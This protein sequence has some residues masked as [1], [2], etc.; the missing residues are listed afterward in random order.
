VFYVA[1]KEEHDL[2][3]QKKAICLTKKILFSVN[4]TDF[5][6]MNKSVNCL[7]SM[8]VVLEN[9]TDHK[10]KKS[11]QVD[12]ANRVLSS[13]TTSN[14]CEL[15][16]NLKIE[17]HNSIYPDETCI[18]LKSD[19]YISTAEFLNFTSTYDFDNC[20][21]KTQWVISTRSGLNS[22]LDDIIDQ[23]L[24]CFIDGADLLDCH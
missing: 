11:R 8:D 23:S 3:V 9:S 20:D 6:L 21:T 24:N 15:L 17:H 5:K 19:I 18:R 14:D 12:S 1:L 4:S 7:N 13:I 16:S 2:V 10:I 22:M